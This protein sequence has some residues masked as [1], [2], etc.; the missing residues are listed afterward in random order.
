MLFGLVVVVVG[1]GCGV[2]WNLATLSEKTRE[3]KIRKKKFFLTLS[4]SNA[5]FAN[6]L[7]VPQCENIIALDSN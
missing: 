2:C 7:P 1:G 4:T 3:K 5:T 6:T